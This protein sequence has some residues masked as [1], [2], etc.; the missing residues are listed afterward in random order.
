MIN[1]PYAVLK[2]Y[3]GTYLKYPKLCNIIN[4]K[5][6]GGRS[7]TLHL[8]RIKQYVDIHQDKGRIY[9]GKVYDQEDELQIIENHGKFTTY[10]RQFLINLFYDIERKFNQT[11][12]VLTNRD[13]LE[14][15]YMVNDAYFIGKNAPYKYI[16][17]FAL[18]IKKEDMPNDEYVVSKLLDESDIFFSSSYRLLKRVVYDSLKS[19]EKSSL[20]TC[21][22]TFRLYHNYT[23]ENGRFC[24]T[25][26]DCNDEEVSKILTAQHDAIVEFNEVLKERSKTGKSFHLPNIQCVHY[27][28]PRERKEFYT[29]LNRYIVN[30]F[31]DDG[32]NAYS[33]AWKINL[34]QPET[35]HYE[36]TTLN[37]KQLN[38]NVQDKLLTAKD[39]SL[40]E[41]TLKK[42]FVNTF[43]RIRG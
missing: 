20:I 22:K 9:I 15:T 1:N 26:H 5:A 25:Q 33:A 3:E 2:Q 16:D 11:S 43:I 24:S 13:I 21:S 7:K 4:E 23:D 41:D 36:L 37:Y 32:W 31:K 29:I 8:N 28:Y 39:L 35:F 17:S 42:Q 19:L 10:I 34:A 38:Q 18:K 12:V 6:R 40:I 30:A 14:M 27:L